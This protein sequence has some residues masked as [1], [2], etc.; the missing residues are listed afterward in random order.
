MADPVTPMWVDV[1]VIASMAVGVLVLA[2]EA[3]ADWKE[4]GR[5]ARRRWP[6]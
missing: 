6:K 1:V 5:E 4:A 3:L 2:R